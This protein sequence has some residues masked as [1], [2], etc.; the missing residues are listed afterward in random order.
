MLNLFIEN[1]LWPSPR[2][3]FY[4]VEIF[5]NFIIDWHKFFQIKYT[6]F[7]FILIF[8]NRL[9]SSFFESLIMGPFYLDFANYLML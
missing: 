5:K 1:N 2:K 9:K 3:V 4:S 6:H 7:I 8:F